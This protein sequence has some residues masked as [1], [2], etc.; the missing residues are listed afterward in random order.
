[1]TGEKAIEQACRTLFE[2]VVD[3]LAYDVSV[4]AFVSKSEDEKE[5]K[6]PAVQLGAD[7]WRPE[8]H[9]SG[10]GN[11]M[12]RIAV[13][14]NQNEDKDRQIMESLFETVT[15]EMTEAKIGPLVES[16]YLVMGVDDSLEGGIA[17]DEE[18]RT[19]T[20]MKPYRIPLVDAIRTGQITTT[21]T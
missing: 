9:G 8:T 14:T 21:T 15:G 19:Q 1:M 13:I 17:V 16:P 5:L 7:P 12:I 20:K 10:L 6:L 3:P 11:V 4:V 18:A 2:A